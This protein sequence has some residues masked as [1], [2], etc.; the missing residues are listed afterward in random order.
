MGM[1]MTSARMNMT[2]DIIKPAGAPLT[3]DGSQPSAGSWQYRQNEDSGAIERMWIPDDVST[4]N[5]NE[6]FVGTVLNNISLIAR[7]VIDG[8]IRVAG[9]TERFSEIYENVD[10]VKATFPKGVP[11]TKRD[12]VTNIRNKRGKE[13]IWREEE[14]DGSP[15]TIFNVMGVTPVLDPFGQ[16]VEQNVLLQRASVQDAFA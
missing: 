9:T 16:L 7:G 12:R 4:P 8:G 5:V 15:A 3:T 2:C 14:L 13:L 6:G 1:C 10:W 11:L